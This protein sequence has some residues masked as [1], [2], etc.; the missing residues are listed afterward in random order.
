MDNTKC[1]N[2][3]YSLEFVGHFSSSF[4]FIYTL[5]LASYLFSRFFFFLCK[6]DCAIPLL[7]VFS[8]FPFY[9]EVK[10]KLLNTLYKRVCCLVPSF[11]FSL[12]PTF[13]LLTTLQLHWPKELNL[14]RNCPVNTVALSLW[15]ARLCGM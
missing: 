15:V 4:L 5:Y 2:S 6:S 12:I 9:V 13:H 7:Q 3:L 14:L 8:G 1:Q 11:L 10:S